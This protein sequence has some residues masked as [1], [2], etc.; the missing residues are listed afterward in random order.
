V[1]SFYAQQ[2]ALT[3][4]KAAA[5]QITAYLLLAILLSKIMGPPGLSLADSLTFTGQALALLFILNRRF[6]GVLAVKE[7]LAR[8]GL[9]A[10]CGAMLAFGLLQFM[11][12]PALPL[13]MGA[14]VA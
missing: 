1:R 5:C 11:P 14:L 13:A 10:A 7:T 9:G 4:L 3:P 8:A 2:D 12:L 6:P